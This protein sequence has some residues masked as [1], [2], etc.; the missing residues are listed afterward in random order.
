M[1]NQTTYK[2]SP[3]Q[4]VHLESA[5]TE[6]IACFKDEDTDGCDQTIAEVVGT[7]CKESG[8]QDESKKESVNTSVRQWF[9]IKSNQVKKLRI[10]K[11]FELTGIQFFHTEQ[12]ESKI[13]PIVLTKFNC[14]N[15][16]KNKYW[17]KEVMAARDALWAGL[18][19]DEVT[20]YE[21]KAEE[22]NNGTGAKEMKALYGDKYFEDEFQK[23][24]NHFANVFDVSIIAV[25][26]RPGTKGTMSAV[27][28]SKGTSKF[29]KTLPDKESY[30]WT[31][32]DYVKEINRQLGVTPDDPQE[33]ENG[34]L[35]LS[36]DADGTPVFPRGL[37]ERQLETL[38][39]ILALYV[40][41]YYNKGM[42][43][44]KKD[45]GPPWT[46]MKGPWWN[47]IDRNTGSWP[48]F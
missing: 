25:T 23:V 14:P 3:A 12:W 5:L 16:N 18:E 44:T 30:D 17:L 27:L 29:L 35:C 37:Y 48:E 41:W 40:R 4:C 7:I 15:P 26:V 45:I 42:G 22:F 21:L 11:P 2:F 38:R 43:S 6:Y 33:E 47:Y 32:T 36:Y 10:V 46:A 28:E 13:K 19:P 31:P 24:L 34:T 20:A 9:A 1:V 8:I 39:K